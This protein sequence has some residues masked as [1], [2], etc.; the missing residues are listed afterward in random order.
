MAASNLNHRD[1]RS[2]SQNE[3]QTRVDLWQIWEKIVWSKWLILSFTCL[4]ALLGLFYVFTT[5]PIY[6]ADTILQFEPAME[7]F[8][9]STTGAE[10]GDDLT[11]RGAASPFISELQI[12][13]SRAVL[14][15][16]IDQFQLEI[17]ATPRY[18]PL[19]GAALARW[20]EP[21]ADFFEQTQERIN[22]TRQ[23][24][25]TPSTGLL[26]SYAWG[27]EEIDVRIFD[28]PTAFL[29]KELLLTVLPNGQYELS[30]TSEKPI[31]VGDVGALSSTDSSME[32][33]FSIDVS[34]IRAAPGK[35]FVLKRKSRAKTVDDLRGR[36]RI[37]EL[38]EQ[39]GIVK[40]ELLGTNTSQ[41][42]S[43]LDAI[44]DHY[45][46]KKIETKVAV[47][48]ENL[49]FLEERLPIVKSNLEGYE[50]DLNEYR[51][52]RGS[53]D[54]NFETESTLERIVTI[55]AEIRALDLQRQQL[56][57]RYKSKHPIMTGLDAQKNLLTAEVAELKQAVNTMPQIQQSY[58]TLTRNVDVNS[59]L[60]TSL[61]GRAEELNI[62]MASATSDM[63]VLDTASIASDLVK[64]K[65]AVSL[66]VAILLG[67][68]TGVF[69]S[70]FK[71]SLAKGVKDPEVLEQGLGLPVLVTI[72]QSSTQ[73]SLDKR[74]DNNGD[75]LALAHMFPR[76][77]SIESLRSLRS[78]VFFQHNSKANN[79]ILITSASPKVGKS[80][81][82]LNLAIVLANSGKNVVLLDADMRRGRL[83][84]A[85]H[86]KQSPGLSDAVE[87]SLLL[88]DV[89]R[90]TAIKGLSFL[91]RGIPP[92][93]P[94]ELLFSNE[95]L[96]LF[97]CLSLRYD[98]VI[99]DTPPVLAAAEA[100]IIGNL[101]GCTFLVVKSGSNPLREIEQCKKHL[102]NSSVEVTGIV[103]NNIVMT[104]K[105]KSYGSYVYQYKT[106]D[107]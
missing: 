85:F 99:V 91:P 40:L 58:V 31:L 29:D 71:D 16:V 42:I 5:Q 38:G 53:I 6:S 30:D 62:A 1:Y 32:S 101:A 74:V 66:I 78:T 94:S 77:L 56:S 43:I 12:L 63:S 49:Q 76:N 25:T 55:E 93:N 46:E 100:G 9:S 22:D 104:S 13:K 47:V 19:I 35:Q 26:S 37:S 82:S 50:E 68:F 28:V 81:I 7:E 44:V 39:S 84:K 4:F 107:A 72:P 96:A 86:M 60:Y 73:L 33:S 106:E 48:K 3:S 41:M 20:R 8:D 69:L 11:L 80:F 88:D 23:L 95:F 65:K 97:S 14:G 75:V 59:E 54:F 2:D 52:E 90:S 83:H 61:L 103:L 15:T 36:L 105:S 89:V 24:Q 79:V 17:E 21:Q 34:A 70:L 98:H 67:L 92:A 10:L 87:Q 45:I 51:L 27:Q 18:F 102:E 64:P 57:I